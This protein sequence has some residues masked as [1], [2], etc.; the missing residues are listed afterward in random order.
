[1]FISGLD[2]GW[3]TNLIL[4]PSF[5]ASSLNAWSFVKICG[6]ALSCW[7]QISFTPFASHF[8]LIVGRTSLISLS[9][10]TSCVTF[11]IALNCAVLAGFFWPLYCIISLCKRKN[12]YFSFPQHFT[13]RIN[14]SSCNSCYKNFFAMKFSFCTHLYGSSS[15]E[16]NK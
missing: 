11:F 7:I 2:A 10:R 14:L 5:L 6:L 13:S 9:R 8:D 15:S 3:Q 4:N 12:S 1:M 16:G